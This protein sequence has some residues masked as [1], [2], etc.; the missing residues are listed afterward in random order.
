MDNT[1]SNLWLSLGDIHPVSPW[2]AGFPVQS[3]WIYC[4]I[5]VEKNLSVV[6]D[7]IWVRNNQDDLEVKKKSKV[8]TI[9]SQ[10][11]INHYRDKRKGA[12]CKNLRE[13]QV[14]SDFFPPLC[15]LAGMRSSA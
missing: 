7:H 4:L 5:V 9:T 15:G 1:Q 2:Q 3:H 6:T 14:F 12:A 8:V 10:L 11:N 13:I